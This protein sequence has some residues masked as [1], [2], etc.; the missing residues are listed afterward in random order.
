MFLVNVNEH[1]GKMSS[2]KYLVSNDVGSLS[3]L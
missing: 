1:A 3:L 2:T